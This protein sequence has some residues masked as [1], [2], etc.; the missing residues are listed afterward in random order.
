MLNRKP[1]EELLVRLF[2]SLDIVT[3]AKRLKQLCLGDLID[4]KP[5]H[6]H[7]QFKTGDDGGV[8]VVVTDDH[9]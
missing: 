2:S 8:K 4:I 9:R 3:G 6:R 1:V 5:M 7:L